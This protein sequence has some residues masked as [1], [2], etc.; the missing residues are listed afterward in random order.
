MYQK[1][2]L[3]FHGLLILQ[4]VMGH[5]I[6]SILF[7]FIISY[8]HKIKTKIAEGYREE[9]I[10]LP[11]LSYHNLQV[12]QQAL[13]HYHLLQLVDGV[14]SMMRPVSSS[15]LPLLAGNISQDQL[16]CENNNT[17][18]YFI[19]RVRVSLQCA[20]AQLPERKKQSTT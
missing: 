8:M 20:N 10:Y 13:E 5:L 18:S 4:K 3:N 2:P 14:A 9:N 17:Q 16:L 6:A 7:S 11:P 19:I 15:D 1:L 12:I